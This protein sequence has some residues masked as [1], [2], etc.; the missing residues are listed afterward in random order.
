MRLCSAGVLLMPEDARKQI[1]EA[2]AEERQ[3]RKGQLAGMPQGGRGESHKGGMYSAVQCSAVHGCIHVQM[4]PV[5]NARHGHVRVACTRRCS[6]WRRPSANLQQD[7]DWDWDR[8][9]A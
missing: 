3:A 4:L 7:W 5:A 1:T 9:T 2:E 6:R 8:E